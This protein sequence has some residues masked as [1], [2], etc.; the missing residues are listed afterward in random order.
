MIVD[1]RNK[2]R[3]K[4]CQLAKAM[5]YKSLYGVSCNLTDNICTLAKYLWLSDDALCQLPRS[6]ECLINEKVEDIDA[7]DPITEITYS[8]AIVIT[9]TTSSPVCSAPTI[10]VTL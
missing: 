2:L 8:C 7:T 4:M 10:T 5:A 3:C 6:L 9:D 1:A